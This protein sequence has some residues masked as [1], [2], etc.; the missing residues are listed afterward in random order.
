VTEPLKSVEVSDGDTAVLKCKV[1]GTPV[2][3]VEW[4]KNDVPVKESW[5]VKSEYKNDTI[6]L[7]I[8][9]AKKEDTGSYKCIIRND[10][11]ETSTSAKLT[12]TVLTKPN[13]T[14][15]LK[16]VEVGEGEEA[17]FVARIECYPRPE[18]EWLRGGTKIDDE[19]NY[20]IIE[21][22]ENDTYTLVISDVRMEDA[23]NVKCVASN[24][25]GRVTSRCEL[26]VNENLFAPQ[27][28]GEV[29]PITVRETHETTITATIKAKPKAEVTWYKDGNP[30]RDSI[31]YDIKSRGNTYN[32]VILRAKPNDAGLYKCEAK[33]EVGTASRT[34]EVQVKG[35]FRLTIF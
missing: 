13:F 10:L 3:S 9:Q 30:L 23:G 31:A 1:N 11:G 35:T 28:E 15:E 21:D 7:T 24:E 29:E 5:R 14:S 8:K 19:G 12:I 27:F 32:C 22:E 17:R 6:T 20:E 16:S 33:N 34:Y 25:V 4:F 18:V 26:V 2:P